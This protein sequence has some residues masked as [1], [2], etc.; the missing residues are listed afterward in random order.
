MREDVPVRI[1]L[2]NDDGID[3]V[4]LHILARAMKPFGEVVIAAPDREFSG[5]G[6]ALGALHLIQPEVHKAHVDG[7]DE[8]WAITG[9]PALCVMFARLGAFGAP[10]D[11]VVSGINPGVNVGR[12]VYHSGTVGA[13]LSGRNGLISGV[14]VS[15]AVTGF[16]VEGQ[17]WDEMLVG[18]KWESAAEVAASFV[19]GLVSAMPAQPVVVNINVPNKDVAEMK[20]WRVARV[21]HEPPRRMS[22]AVL[23]PKE[24][25]AGSY[26]V[27]MQW[28]DAVSLPADTDGGLVESDYVSVSYLSAL[29]HEPRL[30]ME[31][32]EKHLERLFDR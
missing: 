29:A 23:E 3:S 27:R 10:F 15:Q 30:D 18:Q 2:T 11:L 26:Y 19:E 16:G 9:P 31:M 20:G 1:L 8:A 32:A 4:G 7:I 13:A 17:G 21:G 25:H 6:A 24:G 22:T 14:A 5:A 28:G 12:S